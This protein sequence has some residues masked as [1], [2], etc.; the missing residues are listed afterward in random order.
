MIIILRLKVKGAIEMTE[1]L[2]AHTVLAEELSSTS[3]KAWVLNV[4]CAP[5]PVFLNPSSVLYNDLHV[6]CLHN[7]C[8]SMCI[9]ITLS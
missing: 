4:I 3:V 2:I 1:M 6:Y 9:H 5:V 7:S 8:R